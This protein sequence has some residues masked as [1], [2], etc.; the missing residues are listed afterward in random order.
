MTMM[1]PNNF[2]T[3]LKGTATNLW[4]WS[5]MLMSLIWHYCWTLGGEESNEIRNFYY[6]IYHII[7]PWFGGKCWSFHPVFFLEISRRMWIMFMYYCHK[8]NV[9]LRTLVLFWILLFFN[10]FSLQVLP[11]Y[12]VCSSMHVF[13]ISNF[14]DGNLVELGSVDPFTPFSFGISRRMWLC[15]YLVFIFLYEFIDT[16]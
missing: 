6:H 13:D 8:F 5:K 3:Q 12:M 1:T 16:N 15:T 4:W 11:Y 10:L 14:F 7:K 2:I 9:I